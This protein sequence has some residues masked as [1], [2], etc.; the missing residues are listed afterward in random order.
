MLY[1]V[2]TEMVGADLGLIEQ[3]RHQSVA[4]TAVLHA[5][6]DGVDGRVVGEQ[7]VVD[8]DAA[9]AVQAGLL[10]QLDVRRSP[11][12]VWPNHR[13]SGA[14]VVLQ[15]DEGFRP[16]P[17]RITSYNVCYTKLLRTRSFQ[18]AVLG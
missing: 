5:L 17:R 12:P 10:G 13:Q 9:L 4:G 16:T 8:H 18:P 6:A 1:E 14:P 11:V 2:I 3:R 7:G 15:P